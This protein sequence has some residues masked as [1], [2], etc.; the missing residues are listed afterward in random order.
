M[1][2]IKSRRDALK[3]LGAAVSSLALRGWAN[4]AEEKVSKKT[5]VYKTVGKDELR[6]DVYRA[7]GDGARPVVL[8]IHGGAL[9]AGYREAENPPGIRAALCRAGYVVVSIDYRLAPETKLPAI[10]EDVQD[11]CRWVRTKGPGLFA[12]DAKRLAVMGESAGGFLTLAAGFRVEPR[13]AA[14]VS[15]WGYG[16][17]AGAW[18]SRPDPYYR[19]L[20]LVSRAEATAAVAH[21]GVVVR[22]VDRTVSP[23]ILYCRQNGLWPKEVTGHDPDTDSKAFDAFCPIRN[24][25]RRYPPT[26]LIH[27]TKDTDVPYQQSMNMDKELAR[28]GIAHGLV[29]IPDGGHGLVGA[30]PALVADVQGRVLAFLRQHLRPS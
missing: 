5:L 19:R 12:A 23:F 16:D 11:A 1:S 10:L 2:D 9:I 25:T 18:L 6:A 21:T 24:V 20:P 29:T 3:L 8:W 15:F 27:G 28:H 13:P 26:L 14:L 7:P 30:K 17:I 4:A 22:R